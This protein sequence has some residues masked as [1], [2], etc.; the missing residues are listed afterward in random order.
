MP[1]E[2]FTAAD[3]PAGPLSGAPHRARE[4]I[5][6]PILA[7]NNNNFMARSASLVSAHVTTLRV[8]DSNDF[9]D[10]DCFALRQASRHISR[11]YERHLSEVDI[12]PTQFS[13]LGMLDRHPHSTMTELAK[14]MVMDRTTV[15]RALQPLLKRSLVAAS[16]KGA[17]RRRLRFVLTGRGAGKLGEAAAYWVAAQDSFERSFGERQAAHLRSELFRM[18]RDESEL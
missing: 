15:V 12:T 13:I 5:G 7:Q 2:G 16:E 8:M 17:G 10:D 6:R 11:L 1:M 14:A 9:P 18:T 3:K 4:R